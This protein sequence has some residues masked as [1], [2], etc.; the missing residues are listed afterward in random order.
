MYLEA[1][2]CKQTSDVS[3]CSRQKIVYENI[4]FLAYNDMF[5]L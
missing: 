1:M 4:P 2:E 3:M 5:L